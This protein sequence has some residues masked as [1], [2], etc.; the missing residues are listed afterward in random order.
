M[1]KPVSEMNIGELREYFKDVDRDTLL[2]AIQTRD[3]EIEKLRD[4]LRVTKELLRKI[5]VA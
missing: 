3:E 4:H 5:G 1:S 2:F